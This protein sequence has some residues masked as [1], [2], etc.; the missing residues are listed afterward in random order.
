[1]NTLRQQTHLPAGES[2]RA[3]DPAGFIDSTS[4]GEGNRLVTF[5][6][7]AT[8][9]DPVKSYLPT[10]DAASRECEVSAIGDSTLTGCPD[11]TE[12]ALDSSGRANHGA[13]PARGDF[14]HL[15]SGADR[16]LAVLQAR[17]LRAAGVAWTSIGPAVGLPWNTVYQWCQKVKHLEHPS[18]VDL[19]DGFS[20]CGR[21]PIF[22]ASAEDLAALRAAYVIT[23]RTED[24]GSAEEA[25]RICLRQNSLSEPFALQIRARQLA[26]QNLLTD[27]LRRQVITAAVVV[28]HLRSPKNV[29]LDYFCAPGTMMWVRDEWTNGKDAFIR[30]GDILEAD[31]STI[32]FPVCVPWSVGGDPASDKW[33]VKVARFQWLVAIDAA[34]RFVTGF[35][36]TARPKSSYRGEDILG[37]I[38]G[39]FGTHGVWRR[40]RFERGA[41]ESNAVTGSLSMAGVK[42]QTVWSPHQKPFI[43]GLFS[44]MWTKLSTLPGQVGRFRGEMEEENKILTSCQHGAT[45]PRKH[46]P[47]MAD[48]ISGFLRTLTE[49]NQTRVKSTNYGT[50]IPEE[51]WL[52][53]SGEGRLR[54]WDAIS[55]WMFSPA[56]RTWKVQGALVGGSITIAEG[57]SVR[58]DFSAPWLAK[59]DGCE[60][61][62]FFD[63]QAPENLCEAVLVLVQNVRDHKAGEVLGRAAQVNKT[64][65]YAR[66]VLGW[67]DDL[68]EGLAARKA[69]A[70]HVR[71]EVRAILP[72]GRVGGSV[73]EFRTHDTAITITSG[74]TE[75]PAVEA[76]PA[77][78]R[79]VVAAERLDASELLGGDESSAP[80]WRQ[81]EAERLDAAELI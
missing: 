25:A 10:Q 23:N 29:D 40:C 50:W 21:K 3:S 52:A 44:T 78:R 53:Q 17:S 72:G 18:A 59:F 8:E 42:L 47:M 61:R 37:L 32:N 31:D 77:A 7:A 66:H 60:V 15:Q 27:K 70:S 11:F 35:S 2:P 81:E 45:D 67:G 12:P 13:Q 41:W 64:A 28:R 48:V 33:G 24:S 14:H 49:R 65:R 34:T 54:P 46:F 39:V 69:A 74:G 68:D 38:H 79:A 51:R 71:R 4:L 62:A 63:P 73:S 58:F 55:A 57:W 6:R 56:V 43:E 26:G 80:R 20:A 75:A 76:K 16:V 9:S 30:A 1:M 19:A 5:P 36:Y 22:C